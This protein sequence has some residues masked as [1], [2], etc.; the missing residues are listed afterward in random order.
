[1]PQGLT[2]IEVRWPFKASVECKDDPVIIQEA[3]KYLAGKLIAMM[4]P[5]QSG[6]RA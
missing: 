4:K 6:D 2:K 3:R 1:M 5:I